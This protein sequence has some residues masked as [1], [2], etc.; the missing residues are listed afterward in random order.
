MNEDH[1]A[2]IKF[3]LEQAENQ[4]IDRRAAIYRGLAGVCGDELEAK[5]LKLVADDLSRASQALASL[6]LQFN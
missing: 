5:H 6:Q 2:L 4:S 3:V 1:K